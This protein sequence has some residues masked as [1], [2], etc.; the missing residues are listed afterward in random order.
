MT[1]TNAMQRHWILMQRHWIVICVIRMTVSFME[2]L[3]LLISYKYTNL[4]LGITTGASVLI[5][6]RLEGCEPNSEA[7]WETQ[8]E[9][10]WLILIFFRGLGVVMENGRGFKAAESHAPWVE[11]CI[12][13][14][15]TEDA[16]GS[17]VLEFVSSIST[18]KTCS[19]LSSNCFEDGATST[20]SFSFF[21]F[22]GRF[23]LDSKCKTHWYIMLLH[24]NHFHCTSNR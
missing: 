2:I 4:G 6:T 14:L 5:F 20:G 18:A 16:S 21:L 3:L 7:G 22:S 15:W 13:S 10:H 23:F 17:V 1:H 24:N 9:T 12:L 19:H 8:K 11:L